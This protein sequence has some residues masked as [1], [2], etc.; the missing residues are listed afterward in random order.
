MT[1]ICNHTHITIDR[2]NAFDPTKTTV[3]RKK[4]ERDMVRR[5]KMLI[6]AIR[7]EVVEKDGFGLKSNLGAFDFPRDAQKV[8]EF[9]KWLK[10][11]QKK[12][13]LEI[14]EGAGQAAGEK[15]WHNLYLRSAYQKGLAEAAAKMRKAGAKITSR[16]VDAGFRRP[17]HADAAGLLYTRTYG[18]LKGITDAVDSRIS[19][20][21]TRGLIEGKGFMEL[22]DEMAETIESVGIHRSRVLVR[23]ETISA[24]SEASLN[25]YQEAGIAGVSVKSEFITAQDN[26][27][28][29]KCQE[30]EGQVYSI[31]EARGVIPVHPN[32]RCAWVPV[33]E[34]ATGVDLR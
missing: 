3:L 21:L 26:R 29:P 27:V 10:K 19:R 24:H 8:D 16:W 14:I 7:V 15:A 30:L 31:E 34:D 12:G 28:C 18:D 25:T 5:W 1:L 23:T 11:E 22:A 20:L 32:C 6:D 9:I 33:I 2:V 13:V 17:F 4:F